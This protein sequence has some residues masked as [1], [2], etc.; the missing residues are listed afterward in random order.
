MDDGVRVIHASGSS[1]Q[2]SSSH[3]AHT[4]G[5]AGAGSNTLASPGQTRRERL[6]AATGEVLADGSVDRLLESRDTIKALENGAFV[7]PFP[8]A[9]HA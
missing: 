4:F 9:P 8:T 2:L 7:M 3:T 5:P 6:I 1:A